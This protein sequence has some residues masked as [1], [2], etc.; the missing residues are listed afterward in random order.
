VAETV[1]QLHPDILLWWIPGTQIPMKNVWYVGLH[2]EGGASGVGES[3]CHYIHTNKNTMLLIGNRGL[4]FFQRAMTNL[5][6]VGSVSDH[7]VH[8]APC[9]VLIYKS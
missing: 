6:G 5:L 4:G 7:C 2:P 3:I 8:N 9:P 1:C